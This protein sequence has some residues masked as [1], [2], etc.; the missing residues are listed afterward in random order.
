MLTDN[1]RF[2]LLHPEKLPSA[3]KRYNDEVKR[4]VGVLDGVLGKSANGWLVGDK[5][6]YVDLLFFMW[7]EQVDLV[8]SPFPGG[9]DA[10]TFPHYKK[11]HQSMTERPAVKKV[12]DDK[13]KLATTAKH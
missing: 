4:V 11:W 3:Q 10:D 2:N 12:V 6:T 9:W 7:D 5:C 13:V 8:M 1:P